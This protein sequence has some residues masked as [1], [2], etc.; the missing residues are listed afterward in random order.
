M[1]I[2]IAIANQKGG[3]GKTTTAINLAA[4]LAAADCRALIIDC[5]PQ[6]NSTSGVGIEPDPDRPDFYRVLMGEASVKEAIRPTAVPG[7]D[8]LPSSRHLAGANIE[9]AHESDRALRL[10][11]R[12]ADASITHDFLL[13][14]CPPSLDLLTLN[15]LA[16]ADSLLIPIHCEYFAL[17]GISAI[18][19]TTE[20]IRSTLNPGLRIEG[21]LLTMYDTRTSLANQ[22]ARELRDHFDHLVFDTVI[23]RNVRLAEAPSHGRPIL[24]YDV[25]SKGAESYLALARELLA[26][27]RGTA[28]GPPDGKDARDGV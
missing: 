17:E 28:A 15:A 21:I 19:D 3:V 24:H 23:P 4:S 7:L 22:V 8:I 12:L 9:L 10:R 13:L 11:H 18:L 27:V 6:A 25:R 5:D 14:D 20:R 16:A 2:W 1:S 26:R